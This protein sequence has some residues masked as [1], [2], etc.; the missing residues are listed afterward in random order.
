MRVA[1]VALALSVLACGGGV[2]KVSLPFDTG[3]DV[4][5][6][7]LAPWDEAAITERMV[8]DG[9]EVQFCDV[10]AETGFYA[11]VFCWGMKDDLAAHFAVTALA[12][13]ES[14]D[15]A[16]FAI[17]EQGDLTFTVL[18][19]DLAAS[20]E[21]LARMLPEGA[22]VHAMDPDNAGAELVAAGWT[23]GTWEV[24]EADDLRTASLEGTSGERRIRVEQQEFQGSG[25]GEQGRKRDFFGS[26]AFEDGGMLQ[27]TV[28]DVAAARPLLALFD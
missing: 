12:P 18:V 28:V 10:E 14:V 17:R 9:W 19:H 16:Q 15:A 4:L 11:K 23:L 8:A 13:G 21:A 27:V 20:D 22:P 24:S 25:D 7:R 1:L 26:F 2:A 6:L 5:D 3:S